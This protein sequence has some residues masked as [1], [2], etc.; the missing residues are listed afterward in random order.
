MVYLN[1]F[2]DEYQ[3]VN[4]KHCYLWIAFTYFII[5]LFTFL[6]DK[7]MI[8]TYQKELNYRDLTLE[9]KNAPLN[10]TEQ[11][12]RQKCREILKQGVH[13]V[14]YIY[15]LREYYEIQEQIQDLVEKNENLEEKEN[16]EEIKT[17]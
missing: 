5:I 17:N 16:S 7:I 10:V 12:F 1:G 6:N 2:D 14:S 13:E 4:P 9:F 15:N 3:I 11:E 8:W